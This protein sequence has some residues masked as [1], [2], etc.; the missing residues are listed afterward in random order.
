MNFLFD[1]S[2]PV[3]LA[4]DT[5][6]QEFQANKNTVTGKATGIERQLRLRQHHEPGLCRREYMAAFTMVRLSNGM[7]MSWEMARQMGYLPPDAG[8]RT[9][10]ECRSPTVATTTRGRCLKPYG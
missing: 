10:A 9:F 1:R 8:P 6:C 5:I 7:V 3:H 2:Q 4:F